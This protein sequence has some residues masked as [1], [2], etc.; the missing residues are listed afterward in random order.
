[1]YH[2]KRT[3]IKNWIFSF[4][5]IIFFLTILNYIKV[6]PSSSMS[7]NISFN[8]TPLINRNIA[9]TVSLTSIINATNTTVNITLPPEVQLVNGSLYWNIS[10]IKDIISNYTI[11]IRINTTGNFTNV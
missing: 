8:E 4:I 1:M 5:T 9:L 3:L 2:K 7:A 11:I 10:L 6:A